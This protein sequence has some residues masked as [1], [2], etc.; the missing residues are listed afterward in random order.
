MGVGGGGAV[1]AV[2]RTERGCLRMVDDVNDQ[3][4]SNQISLLPMSI[5]NM[6][7]SI[8][9]FIHSNGGYRSLGL[10]VPRTH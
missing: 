1:E 10:L 3:I 4:K 8:H 6:V 7:R 2:M 9:K 5:H